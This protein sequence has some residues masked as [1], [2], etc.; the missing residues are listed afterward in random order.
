MIFIQA[1]FMVLIFAVDEMQYVIFVYIVNGFGVNVE[2]LHR[3][4]ADDSY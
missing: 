4:T 2:C 1:I 3:Y